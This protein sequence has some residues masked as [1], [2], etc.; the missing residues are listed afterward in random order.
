VAAQGSQA[1]AA[2]SA[3]IDPAW[4]SQLRYRFIG[5]DGNRVIA[6]ASVPGDWR[7]Y[8]AGAASGGIWKSTDGGETWTRMKSGLPEGSLGRIGLDISRKRPNIVYAAH[9]EDIMELIRAGKADVGLVY[10]SDSI[11]SGHVRMSD[12]DPFGT[13]VPIQFGLAIASTC[14]APLRDA[15]EKFS[16]FLMTP[17]I[18]KLLVKYGFDSVPL[19]VA[20]PA[21]NKKEKV[22]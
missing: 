10:R 16:S 4:L 12:D 22:Q 15:A 3:R 14:R 21:L 2:P 13:F 5:P 9:S 11:N 18:Q 19:P 1:S 17:R 8:Y 6:V 7:T 20:E